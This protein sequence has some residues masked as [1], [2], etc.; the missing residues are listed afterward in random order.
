MAKL[1]RHVN[2]LNLMLI[3]LV[4]L[5][6]HYEY[7]IYKQ[8]L[9][10]RV[11]SDKT[12]KAGKAE[13]KIDEG[14][15]LLDRGSY[16]VV[17]DKNLFNTERKLIL[18]KKEVEIPPPDLIVYGTI[19]TD[20]LKLAY[21]EDKRVP[22]STP[23]RGQRQRTVRVGEALSG[24]TLKTVTPDKVEFVKGDKVLSVNILDSNRKSRQGTG[25]TLTA[26]QPNAPVSNSPV[27]NSAFTAA[28]PGFPGTNPAIPSSAQNIP[29]PVQNVPLPPKVSGPNTS[30][31]P[32]AVVPL[33]PRASPQSGSHPSIVPGAFFH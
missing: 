7:G 25:S 8:P 33:P 9:S 23:G 13:L 28:S 5:L 19:I 2:V 11:A 10:V 4:F 14:K 21:V 1:L 32:G 3:S 29:I 30:V 22:F 31:N 20:N 15:K 27:A 18:Q 6:G 12:A 17:T 24:Y 26:G 16:M